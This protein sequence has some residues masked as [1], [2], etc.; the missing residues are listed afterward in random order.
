MIKY[1]AMQ[2]QRYYTF[3][4]SLPT[5]I[6]LLLLV[7]YTLPARLAEGA[8]CYCWTASIS[9]EVK[10]VIFSVPTQKIWVQLVGD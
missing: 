3:W 1:S 2:L 5:L 6:L 9:S 10:C 8:A 4:Y 7:L